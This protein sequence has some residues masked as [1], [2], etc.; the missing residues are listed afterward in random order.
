MAFNILHVI[1]YL[2]SQ[3]LSYEIIAAAAME[4]KAGNVEEI[5]DHSDEHGDQALRG[6]L[7]VLQ[8]ITRLK[9]FSFLS[10]HPSKDSDRSYEMH[11]LIQEAVQYG[12]SVME[13]AEAITQACNIETNSGTRGESYY[14][15]IALQVVNKFFSQPKVDTWPCRETY[16]AHA[17]R[18]SEWV[19]LCGNHIE[20]SEILLRVSEYLHYQGRWG[21]ETE[22]INQRA[23]HLH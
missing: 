15:S 23:L 11:K 16:L 7:V 20:T 21:R 9:E 4:A 1:A 18:V 22:L 17:V 8:A 3:N 13:P 10:V 19:E 14:S 6:D 5:V 12:L 2:D